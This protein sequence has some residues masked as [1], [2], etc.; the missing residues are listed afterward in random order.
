MSNFFHVSSLTKVFTS[1]KLV[2]MHFTCF[3]AEMS[4]QIAKTNFLSF[5]TTLHLSN[6]CYLMICLTI[7][8]PFSW[9]FTCYCITES[10]NYPNILN[11]I[12]ISYKIWLFFTL[13]NFAI[14]FI[15]YFIKLSIM[16]SG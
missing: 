14:N 4:S 16:S 7:L 8:N 9:F 1:V 5:V 11:Q 10:R 2:F 12:L 13:F 3:R 15:V 6:K